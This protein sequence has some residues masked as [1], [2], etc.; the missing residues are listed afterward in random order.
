[1][2]FQVQR[3]YAGSFVRAKY[4]LEVLYVQ[5]YMQGESLGTRLPRF[6][7]TEFMALAQIVHYCIMLNRLYICT[8]IYIPVYSWYTKYTVV[9]INQLSM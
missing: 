9:I 7:G 6:Y 8:Q 3:S 4:M 1:M 5:K 2:G